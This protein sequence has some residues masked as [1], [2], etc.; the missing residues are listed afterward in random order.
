MIDLEPSEAA[1]AAYEFLRLNPGSSAIAVARQNDLPFRTAKEALESLEKADRVKQRVSLRGDVSWFANGC[2]V[3]PLADLESEPEAEINDG[4]V[5]CPIKGCGARFWK[6]SQITAHLRGHHQIPAELLER[7][8]E[9]IRGGDRLE[10]DDPR[11]DLKECDFCHCELN[12][13]VHKHQHEK[14]CALNPERAKYVNDL[15][16]SMKDARNGTMTKDTKEEKRTTCKHCG[17]TFKR[18]LTQHENACRRRLESQT[19]PDGPIAITKA[20]D[21]EF[22]SKAELRMTAAEVSKALG[23][24]PPLEADVTVTDSGNVAIHG[25]KVKE[26]LSAKCFEGVMET[27]KALND[28]AYREPRP[29]SNMAWAIRWLMA[30]EA[31]AANRGLEVSFNLHRM[32]GFGLSLTISEAKGGEEE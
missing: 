5:K 22:E 28:L 11:P 3:E 27:A 2:A 32:N 4:K 9:Q 19:T 24:E 20:T 14:F 16:K 21:M 31:E 18:Y 6:N 10:I 8:M 29:E 13:R 26:S 7:L 30:I 17:K 15:R 12:G 23:I 25:V 1:E